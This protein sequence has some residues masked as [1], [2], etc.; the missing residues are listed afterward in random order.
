MTG[1]YEI[2]PV[3][4]TEMRAVFDALGDAFQEDLR[5]EDIAL[6]TRLAE[7]ERA[8]AVRSGGA[9]V[10]SSELLTMR[11][12]VPGGVAAMAGLTGVGVDPVHRRR[13]LLDRMMR[14]HLASIHEAGDEAISGLWA[15]EAGIYGRWGYGQATRVADLTVRSP[16]AQRPFIFPIV[17][18]RTPPRL[19][20]P[21]R[22]HAC[23]TTIAGR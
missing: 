22:I 13:G 12:A 4:A 23:R 15:S 21:S 18:G 8:L 11:L 9:I 3:D 5:D 20:V 1:E 16:E 14:A 7:P 17:C 2:G 10:A 6:W 19:A